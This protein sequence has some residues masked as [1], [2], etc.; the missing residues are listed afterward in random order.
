MA[1]VAATTI[2]TGRDTSTDDHMYLASPQIYS[3]TTNKRGLTSPLRAEHKSLKIKRNDRQHP[4]EVR[5]S[6]LLRA[7]NGAR[8]FANPSH[9]T[10]ALH[11]SLGKYLFGDRFIPDYN[12]VGTQHPQDATVTPKYIIIKDEVIELAASQ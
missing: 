2:I 7:A 4:E 12:S 1:K 9:V 5:A 3:T 8:V 10:Q 11:A 6:F